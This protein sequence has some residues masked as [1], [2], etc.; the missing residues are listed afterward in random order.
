[1]DLAKVFDVLPPLSATNHSA[2]GQKQDIVKGIRDFR[3]LAVIVDFTEKPGKE[4]I[5]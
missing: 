1:M 4:G 5:D 2:N 3:G